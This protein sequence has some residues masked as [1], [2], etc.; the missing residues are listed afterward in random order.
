LRAVYGKWAWLARAVIGRRRGAF[1]T[2]L[3]R[4]GL[5]V[6]SDGGMATKSER[7]MLASTCLYSLYAWLPL[8]SPPRRLRFRRCLSVC[9]FATVRKNLQTDLH[10]IFRKGWQWAS[11]QIVKFCWRS[12]SLS[13]TGIVFWIRHCWEI[14][15]VV[16]TDCAARCCSSA[17]HAL[18]GIAIPTTTSLRHRLLAEVCTVPVLLHRVSKTSHIWLAKTL[19]QMNGF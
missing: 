6:S 5:R 11:E 3:R 4:P 7:K 19:T 17:R 10:E 8:L 15:K 16:F 2:L 13:D 12:G 1:S 18:A 14:R 9:L